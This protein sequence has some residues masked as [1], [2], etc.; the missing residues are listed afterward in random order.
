MERTRHR[1]N[2][3]LQASDGEMVTHKVAN[4][5]NPEADDA[6]HAIGVA[7]RA[8]AWLKHGKQ[9]EFHPVN[10]VRA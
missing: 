8:E 4:Y 1:W 7:A 3:T 5:W 10:V 6:A 9:R 2:V